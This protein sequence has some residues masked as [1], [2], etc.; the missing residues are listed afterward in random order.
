MAENQINEIKNTL[1]FFK[2]G[3][4]DLWELNDDIYFY[5]IQDPSINQ[6]LFNLIKDDESDLSL[7]VTLLLWVNPNSI[8]Q[9]QQNDV[10]PF[11]H[12]LKTL[13]DKNSQFFEQEIKWYLTDNNHLVFE[14]DNLLFIINNTDNDIISQLPDNFMHT[15]LCC[16]NCNEEIYV[17]SSL[18]IPANTFYILS[19]I[20]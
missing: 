3:K 10:T 1:T 16:E 2:E 17:S 6:Q 7:L 11:T 14:K 8:L 19:I 15:N 20:K 13:R 5:S 18:E 4:I 12:F 9:N